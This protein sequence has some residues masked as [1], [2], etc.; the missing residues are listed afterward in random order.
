MCEDLGCKSRF[1]EVFE[2]IFGLRDRMHWSI[3][4]V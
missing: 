1:H 2:K 4:E 3:L